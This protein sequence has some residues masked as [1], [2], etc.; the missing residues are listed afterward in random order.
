MT[1]TQETADPSVGWVLAS[2]W[3]KTKGRNVEVYDHGELIDQGTVE[4]VAPDGNLLWLGF[5]GNTPRRIVE[6]LR[7]TC[8]RILPD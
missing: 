6:R 8:V 4:S 2:D 1:G 7:E 3:T 5:H